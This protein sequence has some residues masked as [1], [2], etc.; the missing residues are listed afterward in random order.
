VEPLG[1][2]GFGEVWK[3]EAPGGLFKAVKHVYGN[4]K[5]T[6]VEGVRAE[7]EYDALN[8]IKEVRHPFVL[9]MDRIDPIDGELIIVMELADKSLHDR[10]VECQAAGLVG[11]PR[12]AL[13]RYIRDAAEALDHMLEKHNL[14]HLDIKPRNLLLVSDRVKVADFGLVKDLD[15]HSGT[16]SGATPLYASPETFVGKISEHSDQYSLAI[17][18]QEL[19]TGQRPFNGKNAR[20]LA[21]QHIQEEPEL[22]VLPEGERAVVARAL[23][24]DPAKRFP[25]CLSFVRALYTARATAKPLALAEEIRPVDGETPP[26]RASQSLD[27]LELEEKS[28][29]VG[30]ST[31]T[32]PPVDPLAQLGI[33]MHLPDTGVLRP[34]LMLGLGGFGRRALLELR[35]RFLDRFGDL[36][37]IP[38]HRFLYLD[39][40]PEAIRGAV[41]GSPE[42]AYSSNEV[43][44]LPLQPMSNYRRR[45]LDHLVEWLPREK[46]YSMPRSLQTQGSR[47]LGRLAFADNHL[48]LLT[49]LR[50]ELEQVTHPD[51]LF[52]SV[53]STGLALRENRPRVYVIAAA[54]GGSSGHLLD[55]GYSL[56]RLLRQLGHADPEITCVLF[57]GA[58]EDPAT[59][60]IEQA[61]LYATLTEINHFTD[62]DIPFAAQYGADGPRI[63]DQGAPFTSVYLL[64]LAHRHP[65]ALRDALAHVGSYLFHELTTPL[66]LRLE[67][68]R[69]LQPGTRKGIFRSFGTFAVWFPRGL[70]L[71]LAA[72]RACAKLLDDWHASGESTA[73]AEVEAACARALAD[74]ELRFEALCASLEEGAAHSAE[75]N[76]ATALTGLLSQLEYEAAQSVAQDD[77]ASWCRQALARVQDWLGSP[78]DSDANWSKGRLSRAL[79]M[80][81][82]E[83]SREWNKRFL[84]CAAALMEHPGHRVAAA[85][86][87]LNRFGQFCVEA[88]AG[89][90]SKL[91]QQAARTRQAAEGLERALAQCAGSASGFN[92]FGGGTR[93]H[94]RVFVDH[95]A[96]YSRQRLAEEVIRCGMQFFAILRGLIDERLRELDFCRQRL[97]HLKTV[98]EAAPAEPFEQPN[99][100]RLGLDYTPNP[101]PSTET[102][103]ETIR[104]TQT[105]RLVLPEG[106]TDLDA[107]A[108]QF[109]KQLQPEQWIQ[110]DQRLQDQVLAALGGLHKACMTGSDLTRS[111]LAAMLASASGCLAE[112]LPT[113]DVAQVGVGTQSSETARSPLAPYM[114]RAEPLVAGS[115]P[116]RQSAFLLVPASDAGKAFGEQAIRELPGLELLSVPGQ[117]DLMFCREQANLKMEDLEP[118]LQGCRQAYH[119][120][121]SVPNVSPHARFDIVDW[122]PLAP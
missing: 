48:R 61:N 12:D 71:R 77:P 92:F 80:A 107:A 112:F 37:A 104:Q 74:P 99:G 4:L 20:Q 72:Q 78:S 101:L 50:R 57:C 105:A 27:D 41:R 64:K 8:R 17:V 19:L 83:L 23:S 18:Y 109:L 49:R 16:M 39:T 70:L 52:R 115:D 5:S 45:M 6:D 103:W 102:Y 65:E 56:R 90:Q 43:Y 117:A 111:V 46:L 14:Q 66:G 87:A 40:D 58:P 28:E 100:H 24:K 82:Q 32:P 13:I 36:A 3:C 59:P 84:G 95:L 118:F 93:R 42:V 106:E 25:N 15:R 86:A 76:P 68:G 116:A 1:S 22:R 98:L 122:V 7:Q 11:I 29:P 26:R 81:I 97:R 31:P 10:Y 73:Q 119:E 108:A 94:L 75:G 21:L 35:C 62:P 54:G 34:T 55:L 114:D 79:D 30:N 69:L 2:G 113:T 121:V 89:Q 63:V 110:L 60:K 53:S 88:A 96:A 85:Q 120:S 33:T 9:S 51:T 38:L 91:D 47:A 44:H 67:R